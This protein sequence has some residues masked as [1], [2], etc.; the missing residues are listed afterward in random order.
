MRIVLLLGNQSNQHALAIKAAKH[1]NVAGIVLE[2]RNSRKGFKLS[3]FFSKAINRLLFSEISRSWTNMLRHY[4]K[5]TE[6]INKLPVFHTHNANSK[7]VQ[8]YIRNLQPDLIMVSGTS[9]LKEGILSLMPPKGIINLHTGLSP[10]VKGGPNCTNWCIANNT[11][12]LIGNTI[13][14]IDK[15]I[16][17]GNIIT[18][19]ITPLSGNETLNDLHIK[20]MEHAHDLYIRSLLKLESDFEGCP[21]VKQAEISE[22][23]LFLTKMWTF[24]KKLSFLFNVKTKKFQTSIQSEE[25]KKL[26]S[27]LKLVSLSHR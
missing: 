15:G 3:S 1:F 21:S 13:M 10:Y 6:E 24:K 19:E 11:M 20:V 9:L 7:E 17:S 16:D 23:Q 4:K 5:G 12:H 2:T 27:E 8:S 25:Y 14:W 22:G 26:I 18:T